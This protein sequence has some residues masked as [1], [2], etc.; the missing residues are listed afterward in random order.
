MASSNN[1]TLSIVLSSLATYVL[2]LVALAAS[3]L[4]SYVYAIFPT[5]FGNVGVATSLAGIV[6]Y[7]VHDLTNAHLPSG[8]PQWTTFL[9][10]SLASAA[11][12]AV[13]AFTASTLLELGAGLTWALS[14]VT[15]LNTYVG[16]NGTAE[17]TPAELAIAT[18]AIGFTL[19]FLTWWASDPTA[20]AATVLVTLIFTAAQ[21]FHLTETAPASSAPAPAQAGS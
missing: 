9:A 16:E 11:Y 18:A 7:L 17:L 8:W 12:G 1:G 13:G 2:L 14:F 4:F 6:A 20:T 21:W 3:V 15:F 5:A 10:V 19:A